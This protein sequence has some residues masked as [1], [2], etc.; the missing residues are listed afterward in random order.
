MTF[1]KVNPSLTCRVSFA[2][3]TGMVRTSSPS[4]SDVSWLPDT[5]TAST[6]NNYSRYICFQKLYNF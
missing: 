3:R 1:R 4:S 6:T 5:E 2:V